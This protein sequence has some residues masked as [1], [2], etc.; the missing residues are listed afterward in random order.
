MTVR[1]ETRIGTNTDLIFPPMS[2]T[3]Q[4]LGVTITGPHG[5]LT[6]TIGGATVD[7]TDRSDTNSNRYPIPLQWPGTETLIITWTATGSL[8]A[9][10]DWEYTDAL[11]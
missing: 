11:V 8:S 10:I 6:I 4:V 7:S 3:R 9:T 1:R 5:G 2:Y